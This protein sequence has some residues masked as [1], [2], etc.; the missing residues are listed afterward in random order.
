MS[1]A[2]AAARWR[3]SSASFTRASASLALCFASSWSCWA[4]RFASCAAERA[5]SA[6]SSASRLGL[7]QRLGCVLDELLRSLLGCLGFGFGFRDLVVDLFL[8]FQSLLFGVRLG[9]LALPLDELGGGLL[10]LGDTLF[11]L[12]ARLALHVLDASLT[13]LAHLAR[14]IGACL[15]LPRGLDCP[16]L[17]LPGTLRGVAR[18]PRADLDG[19]A[20]RRGVDDGCRHPPPLVA[21]AGGNVLSRLQRPAKKPGGIRWHLP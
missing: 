8:D 4:W 19:V 14:A 12:P 21:R 6:A 10:R 20:D 9:F 3:R 11:D 13:A 2:I 16:L 7:R 1:L 5:A 15:G 18:A 17:G